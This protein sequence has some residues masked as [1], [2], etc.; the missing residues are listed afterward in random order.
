MYQEFDSGPALASVKCYSRSFLDFS[1]KKK[2]KLGLLLQKYQ[3][4]A[5]VDR[6]ARYNSMSSKIRSNQ[7]I[8]CQE[9]NSIVQLVW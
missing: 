5:P 3:A 4:C 8:T 2:R 9:T 1:K 6:R 7:A